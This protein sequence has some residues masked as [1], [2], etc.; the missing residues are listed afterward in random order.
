MDCK[1]LSLVNWDL[2]V[3]TLIA[4]ACPTATYW[5]QSTVW[6]KAKRASKSA[7]GPAATCTYTLF[8][9]L[10]R[11]LICIN[12]LSSPVAYAPVAK[13][14]SGVIFKRLSS[15]QSTLLSPNG[16]VIKK[17]IQQVKK[18]KI[19]TWILLFHLCFASKKG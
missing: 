4:T 9:I 6:I 10:L 15:F 3:C 16:H 1:V 8:A 14:S 2:L 19:I 17:R 11:R 13:L 18:S 5:V 12:S 7:Q